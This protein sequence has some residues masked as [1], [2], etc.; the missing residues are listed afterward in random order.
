[1]SAYKLIEVVKTE[2]K[3]T[4]SIYDNN[5]RN[6]VIAQMHN[7]F[8][9]AVKGN[10]T[11]SVYCLVIDNADG[12]KIDSRTWSKELVDVESGEPADVSIKSRVYTHNDYTDDNLTSYDSE[13]LAI[14]NYH[15]KIASAMNKAEC[16]FALT[17][18]LNSIG[19]V[20]DFDLFKRDVDE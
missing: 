18:R 17:I 13:Q 16:D 7:D 14:G 10:D 9:V 3:E 5:D 12:S 20:V 4:Q 8:G 11:L 6:A 15:T 1:M 19:D 2:A